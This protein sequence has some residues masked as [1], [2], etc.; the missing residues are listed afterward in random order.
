MKK[1]FP[2]VFFELVQDAK[3]KLKEHLILEMKAKRY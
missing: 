2:D 1:E 3:T